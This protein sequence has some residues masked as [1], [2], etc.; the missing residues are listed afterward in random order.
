VA[1]SIPHALSE[2]EDI[3]AKLDAYIADQFE[4]RSAMIR[5]TN[6]LRFTLFDEMP[7]QQTILGPTG[8]LFFTFHTGETP[9]AV[10]RRACGIGLSDAEV[11]NGAGS[12]EHVFESLKERHVNAILAL[13][14]TAPIVYR[15]DLPRWL[16]KRCK[17]PSTV[18][19][20]MRQLQVLGEAN[21]VF[22]ALAPMRAAALSDLGAFPKF[23]FHWNG[24]GP[25]FTAEFLAGQALGR[26]KIL[27]M[28]P[29]AQEVPSDLSPFTEGIPLRIIDVS[30]N[31]SASQNYLCHGITC[32][33]ELGHSSAIFLNAVRV[34][35]S[36]SGKRLLLVTDSFGN[37]IAP[38]FAEYY[39][40]V[41]NFTTNDLKRLSNEEQSAFLDRILTTYAPDDVVFLFHDA[42]VLSVGTVLSAMLH[43]WQLRSSPVSAAR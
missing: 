28:S 17:G 2:L 20:V 33:P 36:T 39:P 26:T 7:T 10:I 23:G 31:T 37:N 29:E 42:A 22:Y 6:R 40:S 35:S 27:S 4:M 24:N 34:G 5:L 1:P 11:E 25:R 12:I 38:W 16:A 41:W 30:P 32:F 8:R 14:P 15:E 43:G 9:F 21:R 3:P 19:R 18:E 13:I